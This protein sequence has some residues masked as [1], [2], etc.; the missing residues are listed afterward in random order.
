MTIRA[1][2]GAV[3]DRYQMLIGQ[4]QHEDNLANARTQW[5]LV[6]QGLLATG[7]ATLLISGGAGCARAWESRSAC[8]Q[9]GLLTLLGTL[10]SVLAAVGV[11]AS[12]KQQIKL[13]QWWKDKGGCLHPDE[14]PP[15]YDHLNRSE[16][17]RASNYFSAAAV[18]WPVLV[19]IGSWTIR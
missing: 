7:V 17:W 5:A 11:R 12:E 19:G 16:L 18:L 8:L 1:E 6:V 2:P 10:T 15:F 9:I 4:L 3:C 13:C 14:Y